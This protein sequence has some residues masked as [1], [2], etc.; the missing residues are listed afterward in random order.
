MEIILHPTPMDLDDT[1]PPDDAIPNVPSPPEAP[2]FSVAPSP[3]DA[4]A[5]LPR[6][7]GSGRAAGRYVK[8]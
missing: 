4:I 3:A 6:R 2:A 7:P 5:L 1:R 8:F